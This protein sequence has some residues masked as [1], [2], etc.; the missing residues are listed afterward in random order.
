MSKESKEK[1]FNKLLTVRISAEESQMLKELKSGPYFV[2]ISSYIRAS[3][4]HL[5]KQ[6]IIKN[7]KT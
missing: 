2:N 1:D 4:R 5:Y 7:N 3:I 6:K